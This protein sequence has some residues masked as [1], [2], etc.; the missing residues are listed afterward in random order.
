MRLLKLSERVQEMIIEEM[1]SSGH[2]RALLSINNDELQYQLAMKI[3]DEK[4]TVRE[5]EN[6]IKK[7]IYDLENPVEPKEE[8]DTANIDAIY[9]EMEENIKNIMGSK[10]KIKRKNNDKGKIEIEYY[11]QEELER[12]YDM[13]KRIKK[14]N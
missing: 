13:L 10:V 12:L 8:E 6:L 11:N 4:L 5:T 14:F 3:F 7:V 9:R 1:I 2:A